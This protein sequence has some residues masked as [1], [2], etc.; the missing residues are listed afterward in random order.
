MSDDLSLVP[1]RVDKGKKKETGF[2]KRYDS[3]LQY[4]LSVCRSGIGSAI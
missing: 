1:L 3:R 4:N 2:I